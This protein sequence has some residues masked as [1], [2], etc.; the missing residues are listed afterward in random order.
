MTSTIARRRTLTEGDQGR[1]EY[2]LFGRRS[3]RPQ[4]EQVLQA[5]NDVG[6]LLSL[7]AAEDEP[8]C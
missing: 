4:R 5:T 1:R 2:R 6:I 3:A 8:D 7:L